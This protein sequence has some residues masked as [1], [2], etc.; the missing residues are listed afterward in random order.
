MRNLLDFMVKGLAACA[1]AFQFL[2]RLPVPVTLQYDHAMFRRSVVFYP[3]VGAVLGL[4]LSLGGLLLQSFLPP[5]AAAA[6]MLLLWVAMTGALHLDGLMDTADGILSHRSREQMLEIMK[7]SR[8][9][10]MG[11]V[12]C[13]LLLL[14]KWTLLQQWL[15]LSGESV[16][17]LPLATLWSRWF[18]VVAI[19]RWPY[20]RQGASGEGQ[21]LGAFFRGLGWRHLFIHTV[22]GLLLSALLISGSGVSLLSLHG[23]GL[24]GASA[25]GAL[26]VGWCLS[27][28]FHRKLGGLTGDTYGALNEIAETALL[29]IIYT[30]L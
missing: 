29:L 10:A 9:G 26:L 22:L 18:M 7:D 1:A 2:T 30:V 15:P 20:A 17:L 6:L 25:G 13:V 4:L 3:L 14:I 27:A 21:G 12:A 24:I 23:L 8:V 11:V 5:A 19:A 28:Y 16:W